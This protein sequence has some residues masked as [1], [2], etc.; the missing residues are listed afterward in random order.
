MRRKIPVSLIVLIAVTCPTFAQRHAG[1]GDPA[2]GTTLHRLEADANSVVTI[3]PMKLF[4]AGTV[5][6]HPV[7]PDPN[8]FAQA[9]LA[10]HQS[11][12]FTIRYGG[13]RAWSTLYFF[14]TIGGQEDAGT[15]FVLKTPDIVVSSLEASRE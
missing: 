6:F 13:E 9:T 5:S 15:T 11:G 10:P 7:V 1:G 14:F 8:G 4:P 2:S 12:V 3:R